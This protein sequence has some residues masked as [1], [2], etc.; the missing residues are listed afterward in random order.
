MNKL[1]RYDDKKYQ[2]KILRGKIIEEIDKDIATETVISKPVSQ[3]PPKTYK[4][5]SINAFSRKIYTNNNVRF[6]FAKKG[7]TF[8][9]IAQDLKIYSW[10]LPKYNDL[11]KKS[12]LKEGQMI[13]IQK[14]KKR[15]SERIHTVKRNETLHSISQLYGVRQGSLCKRN[16]LTKDDMISVGQQL[17]LR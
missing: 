13:Y 2:R 12:S 6:I 11:G 5:L 17:K 10:Q 4:E 3:S 9:T 8:T 7:D 14:K 15:S 1:Y 16:G